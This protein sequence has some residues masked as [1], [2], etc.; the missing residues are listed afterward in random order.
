MQEVLAHSEL[1]RNACLVISMLL[2]VVLGVSRL[3]YPKLFSFVFSYSKLFSFKYKED[4]GSGIRLFSAE[5]FYF[6]AVLSALLGYVLLTFYLMSPTIEL[7]VDWLNI[8]TI[9]QAILVWLLVSISI[10]LLFLLKYLFLQFFG[11]LFALQAS[12]TKHF[13][14]FQGLNHLFALLL[15]FVV[16]VALYLQFKFP[17]FTLELVAWLAGIYLIYRLL[18]IF[19]KIRSLGIGSNL[20]IFSYLCST[21]LIPTFV[22]LKFLV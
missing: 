4:F 22:V 3:V 7:E 21:E 8:N 17:T 18:N 13:Q 19:F 6:S 1:H 5:N 16:S 12:Q 20:Y 14:E 2:F 11:W 9:W 15:F 10:Q